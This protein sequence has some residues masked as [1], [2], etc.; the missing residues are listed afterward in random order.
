MPALAQEQITWRFQSTWPTGEF[1]DY[2]LDFARI[3]SDVTGGR[4]RIEML[5]AG[6]VVPAFN[7]LDAVHR[8]TI[9]GSHN[10]C[11]YWVGKNAAYGLFGAGPSFGMDAHML[12]GWMEYGGGKEL[13]EELHRRVMKF[14]VEGF[15][16]GPFPTQPLGWFRKEVKSPSDFA[17]LRYRSSGLAV[18]M[19]KAM[20]AE[21]IS[22]PAGE[23]LKGIRDKVIDAAEFAT[24]TSDRQLGLPSVL[25]V[26]MVQSYHQP[27]ECF[28]VLVNADRFGALAPGMQVQVRAGVRA[29][30]ADLWLKVMHRNS[31][32]YQAMQTKDKVRMVPTPPE[33]L[34]AQLRAWDRVTAAKSIENRFFAKVV[35]SQKQWAARVVPWHQEITVS[36]DMAQEHYFRMPA[37]K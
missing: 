24:A 25:P 36:G 7:V 31:M 5:P 29:A 3:V 32:D 2:A 37:K 15:L 33:V 1:H 6:A 8:G 16:Y 30:S 28:E 18:D 10:V 22:L 27:F 19:F 13:Y 14:N 34:R 17:G 20:G 11:A 35:E 9:D 26:C 12:L 4:L 21:V 23:I